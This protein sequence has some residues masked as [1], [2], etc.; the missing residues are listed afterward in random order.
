MGDVVRVELEEAGL[1]LGPITRP[2][3]SADGLQRGKRGR[4]EL[5]D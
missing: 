1:E 4:T 2:Q 5:Q 3:V